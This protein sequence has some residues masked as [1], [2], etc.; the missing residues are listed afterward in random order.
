MYNYFG[1]PERYFTCKINCG[2]FL[3]LDKMK[4][5]P[6]MSVDLQDRVS[7]LERELRQKT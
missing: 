5:P 2:L 3:T 6:A 4:Q 1:D 7:R